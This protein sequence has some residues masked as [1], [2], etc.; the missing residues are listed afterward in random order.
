VKSYNTIYEWGNI[1]GTDFISPIRH[2]TIVKN[3][4]KWAKIQWKQIAIGYD[5]ELY[6]TSEGVLYSC[7]SNSHV[8][9]MYK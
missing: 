1:K 5:H 3:V 8:R 4:V 9:I 2:E 6:L 7:G